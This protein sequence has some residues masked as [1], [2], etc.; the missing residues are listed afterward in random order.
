[1]V[2][3]AGRSE[4]QAAGEGPAPN[5]TWTSVPAAGLLTHEDFVKVDTDG[6]GTPDSFIEGTS[7]NFCAAGNPG[8]K[9]SSGACHCADIACSEQHC[10][11]GTILRTTTVALE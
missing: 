1:M 8:A 6:D 4:P 3:E 9:I 7:R 10:T 2:S 11:D 5:A